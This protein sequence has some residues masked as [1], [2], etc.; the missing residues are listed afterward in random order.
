M[1]TTE[2]ITSCTER[3]LELLLQ[4][5]GPRNMTPNRGDRRILARDLRRCTQATPDRQ[6]GRIATAATATRGL[7]LEAG[8]CWTVKENVVGIR[9]GGAGDSRHQTLSKML[10]LN[11]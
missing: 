4:L 10:D 2:Q 1:A 3:R 7:V 11:R 6:I 5:S 9:L 8:H